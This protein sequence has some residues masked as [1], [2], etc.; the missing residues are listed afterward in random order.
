VT[1]DAAVREV[2]LE[3]WR[4]QA[5]HRIIEDVHPRLGSSPPGAVKRQDVDMNETGAGIQI[6]VEDLAVQLTGHEPDSDD[7]SRWDELKPLHQPI[8]DQDSP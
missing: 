3:G 7:K 6:R 5:T 8:A 1:F 2:H 4:G